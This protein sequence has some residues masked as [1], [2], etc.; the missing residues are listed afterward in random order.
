MSEQD[1]E[2]ALVPTQKGELARVYYTSKTPEQLYAAIVDRPDVLETVNGRSTDLKTLTNNVLFIAEHR[3]NGFSLHCASVG[4]ESSTTGLRPTLHLDAKFLEGQNGTQVELDFRFGRT[5]WALQR[6]VGL[7]LSSILGSAWVIL[8]SGAL[9]DRIIFFGIFLVF[10]SPVVWRDLRS[11]GRRKK[12]QLALLN[13]VEGTY[14]GWALPDPSTERSPY[15]LS[16][17]SSES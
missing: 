17:P 16:S 1:H 15:R 3:E 5:R 13:V 7:A 10:V 2:G 4:Q 6:V 12:E 11:S 8:G 9:L 14:G